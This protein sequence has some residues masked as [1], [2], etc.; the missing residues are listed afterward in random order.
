MHI[1][2]DREARQI[3]IP[4]ER[5]GHR[6]ILSDSASHTSSRYVPSENEFQI[7][8]IESKISQ[9][10]PASELA[11]QLLATDPEGN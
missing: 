3:E 6:S 4:W 10:I 9:G 5:K 11:E 2:G 8:V 7:N 1:Q